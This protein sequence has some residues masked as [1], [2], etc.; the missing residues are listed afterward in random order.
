MC[1]HSQKQ[2]FNTQ[3]FACH[4]SEFEQVI[5]KPSGIW[6]GKVIGFIGNGIY[7]QNYVLA[8]ESRKLVLLSC[9]SEIQI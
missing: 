3:T 4:R 2:H 7:E 1:G 9:T 8:L 5:L 6:Y